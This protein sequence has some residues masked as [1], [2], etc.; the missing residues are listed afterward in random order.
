[1]AVIP[2]GPGNDSLNG[3]SGDDTFTGLGGDDW[4]FGWEG[5]D[6]IYGGDGNDTLYADYYD[7]TH[8]DSPGT[9]NWVYGEAGDDEIYGG[10]GAN[11]LD[12]GTGNDTIYGGSSGST[13]YG[14]EGN[15]GIMGSDEV[16]HIYGGEGDDRL[17]GLGGN[18]YLDGGAGKDR[19]TGGEGDDI[20]IVSSPGDQTFE[21]TGEGTDTVRSYISWTLADEVE[22]LELIGTGNLTGTG[23]RFANT[24]IGNADGNALYGGAG[25][26][27][28]DGKAGKDSM[29]GGTGN[30]IYVVSSTGDRIIE[31]AGEG[32]DTVRSH[33]DWTLG[34][35][36]ER[37]ELQGSAGLS[38]NGNTLNNTLVGNDGKNILR[39]GAGNDTLNGGKGSD[40]L[41]GGAGNDTFLF[42]APL[43]SSNIDKV[44]DYNVAQDTFQLENGI[45]TGLAAGWLS[46]GA[47]HTGAG[48]HDTSDRI[49][50]NQT[51]G[52]LLFDKDGLGG[53]AAIK[54]A[55]LTPGL[56]M[57]A[58]DLFVV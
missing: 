25:H 22:R 53:A 48:A 15:D 14:R 56:A 19:M 4:I 35:N 26:D 7:D 31:S 30:D 12:G 20:Y 17:S 39:G 52:D 42:N 40:T 16:D 36:L 11:I 44:N 57:T 27:F 23:N 41:V 49:I 28:L 38:G 10:S 29:Y 37:L 9:I 24:L 58:G 45:F 6:R 46:A 18:D 13:I 43:G 54:F 8:R 34:A 51:T 55:T 2:E 47:F 32:A 3:T 50:Y 1:M 5:S 33:I 21:Y